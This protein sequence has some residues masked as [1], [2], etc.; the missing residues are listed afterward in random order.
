MFRVFWVSRHTWADN[1]LPSAV[2]GVIDVR[3]W[4]GARHCM[5]VGSEGAGQALTHIAFHLCDD[6]DNKMRCVTAYL[7]PHPVL[8]IIAV[9]MRVTATLSADGT[10]LSDVAIVA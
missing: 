6:K 5:P 1:D 3:D 2:P 8:D 4:G 9:G 7:G 10:T